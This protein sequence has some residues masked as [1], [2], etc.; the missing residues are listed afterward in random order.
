MLFLCH[1]WD[2]VVFTKLWSVQSDS[3][4][5]TCLSVPDVSSPPSYPHQSRKDSVNVLCCHVAYL[6]EQRYSLWIALCC[7]F[8]SVAFLALWNEKKV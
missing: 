5:P 7:E 8:S 6:G 3:E 4:F 2:G 1:Y